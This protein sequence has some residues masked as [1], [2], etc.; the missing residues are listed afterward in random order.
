MCSKTSFGGLL[1]HPEH[2]KG[3]FLE[4]QNPDDYDPK[5]YPELYRKSN[6]HIKGSNE[7]SKSPFDIGIILQ[8][9][10]YQI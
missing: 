10:T 1:R 9:I 6:K 4:S 3:E 7:E 5:L 8:V 2:N